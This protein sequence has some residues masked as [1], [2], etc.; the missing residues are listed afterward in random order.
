MGDAATGRTRVPARAAGAFLAALLLA[1]PASPAAAG[2]PGPRAAR[3]PHYRI[4]FSPGMGSGGFCRVG[5]FPVHVAIEAKKSFDGELVA[6]FR[7]RDGG[8]VLYEVRRRI[9]L[10]AGSKKDYHLYL[11]HESLTLGKQQGV[12]IYLDDGRKMEDTKE[13]KTVGLVSQTEYFVCVVSDKPGVLGNLDGKKASVK[14][15]K[16]L[17]EGGFPRKFNVAQPD[18]RDLP[19]KAAGYNGVDFVVLY[20]PPLAAGKLSGDRLQAIVDYARGGGIVVLAA[21]DRSWFSRAQLRKLAPLT[22]VTAA[23]RGEASALLKKLASRYAKR[24][25]MGAGGMNV[26]DF[27]AAGF[28]PDPRVPGMSFGHC[29]LGTVLLWQLDPK[30]PSVGQWVGLYPMWAD[31][32]LRYYPGRPRDD[33]NSGFGYNQEGNPVN[34]ARNRVEILD[35]SRDRSVSALLVVFLVVL[36]L[37]LVGPVNYFVLR[38]LD[39]RALSIVTIPVLSAVFVL[40]TFAVG[41]ISR[42]VTTVGRRVTVATTISGSGR[43]DCLT[44]Q[45]VFPA[46]SMLVDVSTDASGLICPLTEPQISGQQEKVFAVQGPEGYV[47]EDH[48]MR[49]WEMVH[50]ESVSARQLGGAVRLVSLPNGGYRL[51]NTSSVKLKD[52]FL[53][54]GMRGTKYAWI[55]DVEK[56]RTYSGRLVRWLQGGRRR[57]RRTGPAPALTRD[58]ALVHWMRGELG[59][60]TV[61]PLPRRESDFAEQAARVIGRDPRLAPARLL[62]RPGMVLFAKVENLDEFEPLR[63]D[64]GAIRGEAVNVLVVFSERGASR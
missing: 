53:I 54:S 35:L 1:A 59:G 63:L 13:Y 58:D 52:A 9:E 31:L 29:G 2:T 44:C 55:G 40:M 5:W 49:M 28:R 64:G 19:D 50:F 45:S 30:D 47:L 20:E 12:E 60:A 26:H 48:P 10:A 25:G 56:G 27:D 4:D 32:A 21:R 17:L 18:L 23:S 16:R 57:V 15:A 24:F 51:V 38:R 46:G 6:A 39:M 43:A 37:V 41:Y 22:G 3:N 14:V 11:R 7:T 8:P 36:Y 61:Y 33:Y 42:G 34:R 62:G